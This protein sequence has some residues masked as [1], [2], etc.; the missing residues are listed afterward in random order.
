MKLVPFALRR[1]VTIPVLVLAFVFAGLLA[2]RRM[3]RDIFP[4][5]GVPLITAPAVTA[6]LATS[7]LRRPSEPKPLAR[8]AELTA[9][10]QVVQNFRTMAVEP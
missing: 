3:P 2:I 6:I 4:D 9:T 10:H 7:A 8:R 1:P 5:L